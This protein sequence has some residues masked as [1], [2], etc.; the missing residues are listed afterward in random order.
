MAGVMEA[1][2]YGEITAG[3]LRYHLVATEATYVQ[4]IKTKSLLTTAAFHTNYKNE[5]F[6]DIDGGYMG[7][8]ACVN[9]G[10][11]YSASAQFLPL[12]MNWSG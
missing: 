5:V 7:G 12:G 8:E 10:W 9:E 3:S 2:N 11:P 4:A 1:E 6:V